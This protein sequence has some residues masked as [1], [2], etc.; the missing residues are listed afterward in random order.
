MKRVLGFT[1]AEVLITLGIIGIVAAIVMPTLIYD[2]QK[3]IIEARVGQTYSTLAQAMEMSE[4]DNSK[5]EYWS[6]A[7]SGSSPTAENSKK[8]FEQYLKPY[9]KGASECG[10]GTDDDISTKC[11]VPVSGGGMSYTLPNGS[12]ISIF[13]NPQSSQ[14]AYI[15]VDGNAGEGP[16]KMGYDAFYFVIHP[17][18]GL[19]PWGSGN[20][21]TREEI[22]AGNKNANT[23]DRNELVACLD[24]SKSGTN[25]YRHGCT[26]LFV[27]DGMTFKDDYPW[28]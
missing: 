2:N 14:L 18:R 20:N 1:L 7:I 21:L 12:S 15:I 13:A 17:D 28:E 25:L 16:N 19:E 5:V 26:L 4:L 24:E 11:G 6:N 9:L 8:F 22:L 10:E 23:G 27:M 3:N